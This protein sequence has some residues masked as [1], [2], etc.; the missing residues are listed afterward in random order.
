VLNLEY[1]RRCH[2]V[3]L[4]CYNIFCFQF[5][6]KRFAQIPWEIWFIHLPNDVLKTEIPSLVKIIGN[7]SP[8]T[9]KFKLHWFENIVGDKF[10]TW[11]LLEKLRWFVFSC[12]KKI[13]KIIPMD[14][15]VGLLS[16]YLTISWKNNVKEKIDLQKN[17]E[18]ISQKSRFGR[19]LNFLVSSDQWKVSFIWWFRSCNIS[20]IWEFDFIL[21]NVLKYMRDLILSS[22]CFRLSEKIIQILF[23]ESVN[24]E[25]I[26]IH[27]IG[28]SAE[29]PTSWLNSSIQKFDRE[30]WSCNGCCFGKFLLWLSI[31][32][33]H[34]SARRMKYEYA[35][36]FFNLWNSGFF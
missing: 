15:T 32:R 23:E 13:S 24:L 19:Q 12:S 3:N 8:R 16:Y 2:F 6:R 10:L 17:L 36:K 20:F 14:L 1:Q 25:H 27:F 31:L 26:N 35:R 9:F 29:A 33:D 5:I 21:D 18:T 4:G 34:T 7:S 11:W 22:L 30:Q 28:I